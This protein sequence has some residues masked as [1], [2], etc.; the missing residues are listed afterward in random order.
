MCGDWLSSMPPKE[1]GGVVHRRVLDV[2]RKTRRFSSGLALF[3]TFSAV[4]APLITGCSARTIQNTPTWRSTYS[5]RISG[6]LRATQGLNGRTV[7]VKATPVP[8]HGSPLG[9]AELYV[10]FPSGTSSG[11]GEV[12]APYDL[13]EEPMEVEQSM[14]RTDRR[15]LLPAKTSRSITRARTGHYLIEAVPPQGWTVQ[16]AQLKVTKS[17][18]HADF[19]VKPQP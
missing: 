15:P 17:T 13:G 9:T 8:S 7:T 5:I 4:M 16:P 14:T 19:L 3:L 1:G 2:S 6:R 10:T 18:T 11:K 12:V